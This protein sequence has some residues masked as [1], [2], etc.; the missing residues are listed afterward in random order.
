MFLLVWHPEAILL[1][2]LF[3]TY[4][5]QMQLD[6]N[7]LEAPIFNTLPFTLNYDFFSAF[8]ESCLFSSNQF[9][10][11]FAVSSLTPICSITI[12]LMC[13]PG[14]LQLACSKQILH[15]ESQLKE[16]ENSIKDRVFKVYAEEVERTTTEFMKH[17]DTLNQTVERLRMELLNKTKQVCFLL[18]MCD[19][20]VLHELL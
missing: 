2:N 1:P 10:K 6:F 9:Q 13:I 12:M 17:F 3:Y 7:L 4:G 11:I 16:S 19:L 14:E 20:Y 5:F 18:L 15:L 8:L